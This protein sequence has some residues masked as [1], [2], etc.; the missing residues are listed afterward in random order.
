[1]SDPIRSSQ[2][3]EP[4]PVRVLASA[5]AAL[6]AVVSGLSV[7]PGIPAWVPPTVGVLGLGLTAYMGRYTEARTTPWENVA[8]KTTPTGKVIAGPAATQPTGTTVAMITDATPAAFQPA[9]TV[10]PAPQADLP[11]GDGEPL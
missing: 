11:E 7:I 3:S 5:G 4:K 10:Y 9:E 1:M 6:L 8:A 2:V